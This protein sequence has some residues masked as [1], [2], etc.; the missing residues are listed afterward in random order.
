MADYIEGKRPVIEAFRVGVPLKRILIGDFVK[1]DPMIEDIMR[2][3][4]RFDVPVKM[5]PRKTLDDLSA[6]GS[7]QGVAAE[8]APFPY[9]GIGEIIDAAQGKA[10]SCD[11]AALVVLCDHIT[12][13]SSWMAIPPA[14]H[15]M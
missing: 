15:H 11:G 8:A 3:A 2:K 12:C 9:V 5:V 13:K 4:R 7:H 14:S 10:E 6:R 1:R